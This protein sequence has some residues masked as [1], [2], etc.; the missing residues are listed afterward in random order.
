MK[1]VILLRPDKA[2]DLLKTIPVIRA[3]S[4]LD[5]GIKIHVIC[6]QAN[7]S[8]LKFE[9]H[10]TYSV[11]SQDWANLP[12]RQLSLEIGKCLNNVFF[13][14][15]INLLCDPFPE[16]ENLLSLLPAQ[17]KFS[18]YSDSLPKEICP[19][20]LEK[21][22]PINREE[23]LNIAELVEKALEV[24]LK[25]QTQSMDRSP[26]IT[27]EDV[28]E[29]ENALGLKQGKW[30]AI[31]PFAGTA[32]RTHSNK[33]WVKFIRLAV[34]K[35]SFNKVILF[36]APS[37]SVTLN[38][39]KN[40]LGSPTKLAIAIP[41]SFRTLGAYLKQCDQ[42]IAVDSGPLHLAL[43]LGIPSLGFLSGGDHKRWFSRLSSYDKIVTRGI[44]DRF[45]S[46]FEMWW[47]F[48]RWA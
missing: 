5:P 35:P 6:S 28:R 46:S 27:A 42:V 44:L 21:G 39:F 43:A 41:S 10:I 9:P 22:S 37:D 8:I 33:K 47:H 34:N 40:F 1:S 16:V 25:T 29:A 18:I 19:L 38:E 14:T 3:L 30:L 24:D 20:N 31:C 36:G 4:K 2:G 48:S 7:H 23:T 45:P 15:A 26:T 12:D 13:D 32:N 11:L 17:Q